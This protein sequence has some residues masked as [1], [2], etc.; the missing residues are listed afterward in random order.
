MT[1]TMES[2]VGRAVLGQGAA[3]RETAD[4]APLGALEAEVSALW[5]LRRAQGR[6]LA[7]LLHPRLDP[8]AVPLLAALGTQGAVRSTEL[9][10]RLRLDPST[11]SRQISAAE[12]LG[13]VERLPDPTDARARLVDLTPAAREKYTAFRAEQLEHWQRSVH[14]WSAADVETLTTLLRRL[15]ADWAHTATDGAD[16]A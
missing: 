10:R 1:S 15:R 13:L 14:D 11:L 7:R 9:V 16:E 3:G 8:S 5:Q 4:G 6:A 2:T 12:R